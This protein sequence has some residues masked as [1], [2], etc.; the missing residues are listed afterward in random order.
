MEFSRQECW[1]EFPFPSPGDLSDPGTE[2]ASPGYPSLQADSLPTEPPGKPSYEYF[3]ILIFIMMISTLQREPR[4]TETLCS[5]PVCPANT[6]WCP[7][8]R[9]LDSKSSVLFTQFHAASY[10]YMLAEVWCLKIIAEISRTVCNMNSKNLA[11]PRVAYIHERRNKSSILL[12][13][14]PSSN[15]SSS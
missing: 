7:E 5:A 12:G 6:Y 9:S 15:V 1:S 4:G 10:K 11:D 3:V 14:L 2:L 8:T 13:K